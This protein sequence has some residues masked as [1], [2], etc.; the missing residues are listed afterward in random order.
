MI[1]LQGS[2]PDT[3][4]VVLGEGRHG[5]RF[6]VRF[7]IW[8]PATGGT[9]DGRPMPRFIGAPS[10]RKCSRPKRS[11]AETRDM[12]LGQ[13]QLVGNV[14][15]ACPTSRPARFALTGMRGN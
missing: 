3:R 13:G 8:D 9:R 11:I 15:Q 12:S 2:Y 4:I 14:E 7:P 1:E 6:N 10:W 5:H